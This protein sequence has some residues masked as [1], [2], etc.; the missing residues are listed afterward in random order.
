MVFEIR[1]HTLDS[2]YEQ[3]LH[4][5][6]IPFGSGA[7][8]LPCGYRAQCHASILQQ[9]SDIDSNQIHGRLKM[10]STQS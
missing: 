1:Q 4:Q 5:H 6:S 8:I 10:H 9:T 2:E 7:Q 3:H